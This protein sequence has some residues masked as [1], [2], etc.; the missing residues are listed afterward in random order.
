MIINMLCFSNTEHFE[1]SLGINSIHS[2]L[3]RFLDPDDE[4]SFK[5]KFTSAMYETLNETNAKVFL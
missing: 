5:K 1:Y 3:M 2:F 4:V